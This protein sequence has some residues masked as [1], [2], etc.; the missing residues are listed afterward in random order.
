MQEVPFLDELMSP[1]SQYY[2]SMTTPGTDSLE[3]VS[4]D[5]TFSTRKI[6]IPSDRFALQIKH[7]PLKGWHLK[8]VRD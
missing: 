8:R 6:N 7:C 3:M 1:Q 5:K 2:R 4:I